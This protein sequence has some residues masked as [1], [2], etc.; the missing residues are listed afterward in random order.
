MDLKK[1]GIRIL[2]L[3]LLIVVALNFLPINF[4]IRLFL[5]SFGFGTG[6]MVALGCKFLRICH[7]NN[8]ATGIATQ[9]HQLREQH[10]QGQPEKVI[11]YFEFVATEVRYWLAKL[12]VESLDLLIGRTDLLSLVEGNTE[13]QKHLDLQVILDSAKRPTSSRGSDPSQAHYQNL[14][15]PPFDKGV[16]NQK[17]LKDVSGFT[18]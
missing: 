8:C 13:Q 3:T 16:M 11:N 15:N 12:G 17:I 14:R 5:S 1:T 6:P 2:L 7:L 18:A 4:Q 9:N 10:Y